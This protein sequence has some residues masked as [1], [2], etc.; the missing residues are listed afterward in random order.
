MPNYEETY[1]KKYYIIIGFALLIINSSFSQEIRYPYVNDSTIISI[2]SYYKNFGKV[3]S[4]YFVPNNISLPGYKKGF[5]LTE[6]NIIKIENIL[7]SN[8]PEK[9]KNKQNRNHWR[10]HWRQYLAYTNS[11]GEQIIFLHLEKFNRKPSEVSLEW[12]SN[13][14][15]IVNEEWDQHK[16]DDFFINLTDNI[17]ESYSKFIEDYNK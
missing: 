10:N 3:F 16:T 15:S 11:Y 1:M 17:I 5:K 2:P 4:E 6:S 13:V 12:W 9:T 7:Q 14:V 8:Y